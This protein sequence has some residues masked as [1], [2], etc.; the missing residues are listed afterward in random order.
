MLRLYVVPYIQGPCP[1]PCPL[2]PSFTLETAESFTVAI[3]SIRGRLDLESCLLRKVYS[4]K[5]EI[6]NKV[7]KRRPDFTQAKKRL[8][9]L[10]VTWEQLR[11]AQIVIKLEKM[12]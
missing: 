2:V 12:T 1:S 5:S 9:E 4:D 11:S 10:L 7:V 6:R 3:A 8:T